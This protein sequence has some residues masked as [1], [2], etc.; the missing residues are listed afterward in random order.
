LASAWCFEAAA[1]LTSFFERR[2][3]AYQTGVTG[4]VSF[5]FDF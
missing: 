1:Q 4:Q 2:V 3:S 5:D